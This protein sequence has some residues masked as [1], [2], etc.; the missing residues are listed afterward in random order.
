VSRDNHGI[1]HWLIY[2]INIVV[3]GSISLQLQSLVKRPLEQ[4]LVNS[5]L[6]GQI[7]VTGAVV[8]YPGTRRGF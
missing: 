6:R 3:Q 4:M 7:Y 8:V 2:L 1:E 5:T